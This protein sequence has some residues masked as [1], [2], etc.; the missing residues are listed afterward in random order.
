MSRRNKVNPGLYTQA[1]RLTPDDLAREQ[2][3]QSESN[4]GAGGAKNRKAMAPW[5]ANNTATDNSGEQRGAGAD[6]GVLDHSDEAVDNDDRATDELEAAP[7]REAAPARIATALGVSPAAKPVVRRQKAATSAGTKKSAAKKSAI[8][9]TGRPAGVT[10]KT[11]S[12]RGQSRKGA[13]KKSAV[14]KSVVKRGAAKKGAAKT[15]AADKSGA[16]KAA[17]KKTRTR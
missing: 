7:R 11:A 8:T 12:S 17:A 14:K 13:A 5:M 1:G 16:R 15:R 4:M 10:Q 6:P 2:R 9:N 3:K